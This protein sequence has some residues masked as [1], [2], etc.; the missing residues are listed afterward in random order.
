MRYGLYL[1]VAMGIVSIVTVATGQVQNGLLGSLPYVLLLAAVIGI[2]FRQ[3]KIQGGLSLG[4]GF[5]SGLLVSV[6]GG[7]I[8]SIISSA[9]MA[10][11]PGAK[12]TFLELQRQALLENPQI[13]PEIADQSMSITENMLQP[14]IA[15]PV[16]ILVFA[17]MGAIVSVIVA[18]IMKKDAAPV[19]EMDEIGA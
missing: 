12:E 14:Y 5:K 11:D 6:V 10:I 15:I 7:G 18:A 19:A 1:G 3:R 8:S 13:T 2:C 17:I 9:H 16:S 4:E